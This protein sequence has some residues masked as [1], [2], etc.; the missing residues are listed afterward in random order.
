MADSLAGLEDRLEAMEQTMI[1]LAPILTE[2]GNEITSE[3]RS[4]APVAAEDGGA[5]RNSISLEVQSTQFAISMNDYGAFQ[6]YGVK[7]VGKKVKYSQQE[8]SPFNDDKIYEFG[9]GNYSRGGKPWGAYYSGLGPHIGWFDL[10]EITER[11]KNKIQTK[12]IQAF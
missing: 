4:N 12:I 2:V 3:L 9:T 8:P 6:N 11:V 1:D 5:L 10:D 7:G